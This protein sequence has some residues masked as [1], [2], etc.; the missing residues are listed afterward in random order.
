MAE[1]N[2]GDLLANALQAYELGRPNDVARASFLMQLA[3]FQKLE[4]MRE[5]MWFADDYLRT[6]LNDGIEVNGTVST[7]PAEGRRY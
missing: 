3:L 1:Q 5:Q 7:R 2:L 4:E 6:R